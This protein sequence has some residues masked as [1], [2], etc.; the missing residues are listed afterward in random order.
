MPMKI[1]MF[2][3]SVISDWNHGNAHFLR[4]M[5]S[6]FMQSGHEVEVYEPFDGWSLKNLISSHGT[7]FLNDFPKKFFQI[8]SL[9]FIILLDIEFGR[10]LQD[11]DI[12]IVHE[13]NDPVLIERIGD[14]RALHDHFLLFFHDTHHRAC[15]QTAGNAKV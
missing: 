13:W 6:A 2:Y 10:V 15:N 5:I 3:H 12:V 7:A 4:G 11:A 9:I 8:T 1:Y 14:Y